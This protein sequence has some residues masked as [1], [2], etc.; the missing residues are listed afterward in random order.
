MAVLRN[1][2]IWPMLRD[3]LILTPDASISLLQTLYHR[4]SAVPACVGMA[5]YQEE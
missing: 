3:A 2:L 4:L 1:H 5:A